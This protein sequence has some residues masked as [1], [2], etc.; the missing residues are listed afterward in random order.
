[1]PVVT[2]HERVRQVEG[3][4]EVVEVVGRGPGGSEGLEEADPSGIN[5]TKLHFGR[6][7]LDKFFPQILDNFSAHSH[8]K[9]AY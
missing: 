5:F 8:P 9:T 7:L 6:K 3:E 1:V 2:G 4:A